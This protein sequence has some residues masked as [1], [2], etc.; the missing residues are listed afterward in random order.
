MGLLSM[1]E[2]VDFL[3]GHMTIRS[4]LGTGTRIAVRVPAG[5]VQATD[6]RDATRIA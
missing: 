6:D 4:R 5:N 2:R 3:D 1:R